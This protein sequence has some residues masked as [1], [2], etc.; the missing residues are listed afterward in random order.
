MVNNNNNNDIDNDKWT[1][2]LTIDERMDVL[3]YK[4][5]IDN[6]LAINLPYT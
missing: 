6:H 5:G 1:A 2:G 3:I 4:H